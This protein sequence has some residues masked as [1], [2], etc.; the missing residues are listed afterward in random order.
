MEGLLA[1]LG[2][3]TSGIWT[4]RQNMYVF[5][6]VQGV[7]LLVHCWLW[8]WKFSCF[9]LVCSWSLSPSQTG[10]RAS[11]LFSALFH[12][13]KLPVQ[14]PFPHSFLSLPPQ[15]SPWSFSSVSQTNWTLSLLPEACVFLSNA[16]LLFFLS[17][18]YCLYS[19]CIHCL[20]DPCPALPKYQTSS[21]F[22]SC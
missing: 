4:Y 5:G 3:W 10:N 19:K 15:Q 22:F 20:T 2:S 12:D 18:T 21:V 9:A 14:Y 7:I 17:H 11:T 1:T 8:E 13:R 16:V 6:S